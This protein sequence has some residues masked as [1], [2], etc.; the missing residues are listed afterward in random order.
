MH[1]PTTHDS[2]SGPS[3]G[4]KARGRAGEQRRAQLA[5]TQE[6]VGALASSTRRPTWRLD[7]R[8]RS[9]R[10]VQAT[11]TGPRRATSNGPPPP[12][13]EEA[14]RCT[15]AY[16]RHVPRHQRQLLVLSDNRQRHGQGNQ[17]NRVG[18]VYATPVAH[19]WGRTRQ[20]GLERP[21]IN[22]RWAAAGMSLRVS[23]RW[24]VRG[25]M[26][27]LM[28]LAVVELPNVDEHAPPR[29][30]FT[31]S[32]MCLTYTVSKV[33]NTYLRTRSGACAGWDMARSQGP[34]ECVPA[35]DAGAIPGSSALACHASEATQRNTAAA[36]TQLT[37]APARNRRG[38]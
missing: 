8:E 30:T 23:F 32:H 16:R 34:M 27:L 20:P 38:P 33:K 24:A 29:L 14:T 22:G 17:R 31:V 21:T 25:G 11:G 3:W 6:S 28:R 9:P 36:T 10:H 26:A 15:P 2:S 35:A 4:G 18:V 7:A 5:P 1:T 12:N 13:H 19:L 37:T